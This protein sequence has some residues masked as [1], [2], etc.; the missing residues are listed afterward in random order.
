[1]PKRLTPLSIVL[2]YAAVAAL[3]IIASGKLLVF[4]V[5]DAVLQEYI[6]IAKGL[7]FVAVTSSLLYLLLNGWR[8]P[9][10]IQ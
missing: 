1:M 5:D 2:L 10:A 9:L 6:E 8:Q 3:W 4:A 7:A